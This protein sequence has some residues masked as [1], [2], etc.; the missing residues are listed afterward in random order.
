[1]KFEFLDEKMSSF[2]SMGMN[3][4]SKLQMS[5]QCVSNY[6]LFGFDLLL[7][8]IWFTV[9]VVVRGSIIIESFALWL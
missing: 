4:G 6:E 5:K 9:N 2:G 8:C 3:R 1:M 7:A